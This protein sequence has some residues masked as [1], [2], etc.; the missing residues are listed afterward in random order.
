[1]KRLDYLIKKHNVGFVSFGDENFGTDKRWLGPFIDEISKRDLIWSVS[2]MRV[3]C[4]DEEWIVK[5]KAAGCSSIVYGMESGSQK[6][7]DIMEKRTTTQ[8]NRDALKWTVKH[9]LDTVVQLVIGMPGETP[10][11]I[12]ES[13]DFCSYFILE[14]PC[15][16]FL[17]GREPINR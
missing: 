10:E 5:M 3:N 7:L 14:R 1:M 17:T 9:K 15:L 12:K 16:V 2:G 4:I 13:A 11:T 8:Q 6:M